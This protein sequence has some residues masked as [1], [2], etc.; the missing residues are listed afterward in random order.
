MLD[1]IEAIS[2]LFYLATM[3]LSFNLLRLAFV[4]R[5]RDKFVRTLFFVYILLVPLYCFFAIL[6]VFDIYY[7]SWVGY[8]GWTTINTLFLSTDAMLLNYI[9]YHVRE[10]K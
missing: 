7:H 10:P 9:V 6:Y 8:I 4:A 2:K 3:L 5:T 1:D